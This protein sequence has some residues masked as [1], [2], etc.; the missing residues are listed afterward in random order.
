LK[1]AALL[2]KIFGSSNER[3][4]KSLSTIVKKINDLEPQFEKL[5]DSQLRAK[6]EEFKI[7]IKNSEDEKKALNQILPEAFAVVREAAKR[8]LGQRHYDVQMIGGIVLHE[9]KISEMKTGE[10]KTLVSTLPTYL[11]ALTGKGVHIV[12][13]NEYLAKRDAEWMGKVHNFLGLSV[14]VIMHGQTSQ[15]KQAAYNADITYGTNHEFGF[16][17]LRDNMKF[18]LNE[19]A[20]RPFNYAII[21]EVDSILIDEARTP[22][23]ISGPV[24]DRTDLYVRINKI[25]PKL[26]EKD[27]DKDEK[28]NNIMFTEDGQQHIEDLL[29][30]EGVIEADSSLY[31]LENI[32]V[33]H[34]AN[35]ALKAHKMFTRDK[36][37]LVKDGK[38][39]IIDEFTGRV[40]EGRRYSDG[41]HQAIEAKE[42]VKV[43]N[44]NQT[45]ASITYQNYFRLYP[46]LAGMTGT[47]MTEASEFEEIYKLSVCEIP[48]N[49]AVQRIDENDNIYRT[50][51]EKFEA[52]TKIIKECNAKNQ[53]VLAGTASVEKSE[54]LS[55]HLKKAGIKHSILNAKQHDKEALTI[56]QAGRPGVVTVATNMAGRGTDIQLGGNIELL[57]KDKIGD[58]TDA[59]YIKRVTEEVKAQVEK[60]K[61]IV[62]DAG[63]LCVLGTERHE[64][65]RIDNQL[66]G[67]SGRQGDKGYSRF[68]LSA[69]DDLIRVFG[70]DK[71]MDWILG[72]MGTPG[73][74]IEHPMLTR[75]MEKAQ[76]KVEAR[77]FEIRRNLLKFDDVM[78]E[79]RKAVY[80]QRLEI[81]KSENVREKLNEMLDEQVDDLVSAYIPVN[82]YP[83]QWQSETLQHEVQRIFGITIPIKDWAEEE[84]VAD[85]EIFSRITKLLEDELKARDAKF[86]EAN[87]MQMEKRMLLFTLDEVWKDH[88]HFLDNLR[89]GINLRAYAQKDPLNEYKQECFSAFN[90]MLKILNEKYL[91]RLF[92]VQI[93]ENEN[94]EEEILG[95]LKNRR[96]HETNQDPA[97]VGIKSQLNPA[98]QG[99]PKVTIRT[100]VKPA[101]RIPTDPSTWGKV[102]RNEACPCGSGKKYKSCHGAV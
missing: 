12:T 91:S 90:E 50:E 11:N 45:L 15:E 68:F 87:I 99:A 63:G 94:V 62:R 80:S 83:E 23:I 33:L 86:G 43:E 59:A 64:S 73:E 101:D 36:D 55:K 48:T 85:A 25:L 92:T 6:T 42:N 88:L 81:M 17:Y 27:Y 69:E 32:K 77:N 19:M 95:L 100:H 38:V 84:G 39:F 35:N 79:Q 49:V 61:I 30:E 89:H 3:Y 34:H 40:M 20:Q 1:M 76:A 53:P 74:P 71:K 10:G 93:H 58:A 21:D 60:D 57:V 24:E 29:K 70:A 14:G 67:R 102:S 51:A 44:E 56:A 31:D 26:V 96:M 4:V 16:D 37:Y 66:R 54:L 28:A 18:S 46:K 75:V 72:K 2:K 65:R 7:K 78:N 52:I 82:S 41:L 97:L 9:G 22:L 8:T 13:V 5:S 47:A 98:L